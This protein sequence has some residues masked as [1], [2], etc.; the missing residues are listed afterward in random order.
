M[1]VLR[2]T[3]VQ[4]DLFWE[5]KRANLE[6]I[7]NLLVNDLAT[8]IVILPEMFTTGFSMNP[9]PFAEQMDGETM[10][11]LAQKARKLNAAI[12][13][14]FI[15]SENVGEKNIFFNRLICMLPNGKFEYYDKKHLFS[16]A[17][18][19]QFYTAGSKRVLI[20]WRG[21]NICPLICYDL[22]F[23][24]WSRN[25]KNSPYDV[26]IYVANWP[27]RRVKAWESL[28]VA[29]AIEN[30]CFTVGVNRVGNDGNGLP[31]SGSTS[32]VD[33]S[34]ER[35]YFLSGTEGVATN[36]LSKKDLMNF[37][38]NLPFLE[39]QDIFEFKI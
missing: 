16:L 30:Q 7:D 39:D 35:L 22:R 37:R 2:I 32:I 17:G 14:S 13:G 18:E 10:N 31:H 15:V 38:K 23:P 3:T 8:D 11:W 34:G 25:D 21:W 24:V 29:R 19:H 1:S 4:I 6:K 5:N 33:F 9:A 20:N 26:L 36:I 28:L 27:Q 12:M